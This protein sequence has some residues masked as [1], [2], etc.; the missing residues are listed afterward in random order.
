[1]KLN[2]DP[3]DWFPTQEAKRM[4]L[5]NLLARIGTMIQIVWA[6]SVAV[7]GHFWMTAIWNGTSAVSFFMIPLLNR[8]GYHLASRLTLISL[9]NFWIF[10][11]ANLYAGRN[12]TQYCF[13][14]MTSLPFII[15]DSKDRSSTTF[16]VLLPLTLF[17][18]LEVSGF[19]LVPPEL[20]LPATRWTY[21]MTV[22]T[23]FFM[24]FIAV[25]S[26]RRANERFE[27]ELRESHGRFLRIVESAQEGICATNER[28]HISYANPALTRMLGMD[29]RQLLGRS[30]LDLVDPSYRRVG[31]L[32][33]SA[34]AGPKRF[35]IELR[36]ADGKALT[37]WV[38][39]SP[40]HEEGEASPAIIALI[41]DITESQEKD[42]LF[43]R[44]K[45]QMLSS[46]KLSA[47]GEMAAGIA[48]EINNPLTAL[49]L[50]SGMITKYLASKPPA[51]DT[52]RETAHAMED[53]VERI[54]RIIEGLKVFS[55]EDS[56]G[57][58]SEVPMVKIVED[59]LALCSERFRVHGI[60][61]QVSEIPGNLTVRAR[62]VQIS[63]VLLNLLNNAFHAVAG[64]ASRRVSIGFHAMKGQVE[65]FVTDN[66]PGIPREVRDKIFQ[67]F[68]TTK[69]PGVGTGLGLSISKGI[70][71][72]H[73]GAMSYSSKPGRT[74]FSFRL[75][76]QFKTWSGELLASG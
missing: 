52:A 73:G 58:P 71:E 13:L 36:R 25:Y 6:I 39:S 15:F 21:W 38:S 65:I 37:T 5:T 59:T 51:I 44:Q 55:R 10:A 66:G 40:F 2:P 50:G 27:S 67:P 64:Q 68:F 61:L 29:P 63:Q 1:V 3:S 30:P 31:R 49:R 42:K 54:A 74:T 70:I 53:T 57:Q 20:L 32:A 28:G 47:L 46:A 16:G 41:L 62:P 76:A 26:F 19:K 33:F 34:L 17:V 4:R 7:I 8:Y 11:F 12:G 23:A 14:P 9:I 45:S 75:P 56:N 35:E 43:R 22:G 72:S 18:I 24:S 60:H 69:P 48:H